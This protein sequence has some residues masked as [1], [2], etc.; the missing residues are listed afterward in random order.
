MINVNKDEEYNPESDMDILSDNDDMKIRSTTRQTRSTTARRKQQQRQQDSDDDDPIENDYKFTR[1][2]VQY[3]N[4]RQ[5]MKSHENFM[6]EIFGHRNNKDV[7]KIE[8]YREYQQNDNDLAI[9]IKLFKQK[10]QSQWNQQD[11]DHSKKWLPDLYRHLCDGNLLIHNRMLQ[12]KHPHSDSGEIVNKIV[13]PFYLRGKL[14]DYLH[15]NPMIHHYSYNYTLDNVENR[16]YWTRLKRDVRILTKHCTSCQYVKGSQ[17]HRTPLVT[18]PQPKPREH[19]FCDILGTIYSKYNILV[20]IDYATGYCMLLPMEGAG[21]LQVV[22]A[23]VDN[24]FRIFG[25]FY[26]FESDWG[27]DFNNLIMQYLSE[28]LDFPHELAEPRNHHSIG[29]VERVLGFVQ[30]ILKD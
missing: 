24:W 9:I 16:F 19:I 18:R 6:Y 10:D 11:I 4:V 29:K 23:I 27:S 8:K 14:L 15:H 5:E 22:K 13:V 28:L 30:S 2:N 26:L 12:I 7:L 17:R 20:M 3:E 21:A 25:Y 1:L